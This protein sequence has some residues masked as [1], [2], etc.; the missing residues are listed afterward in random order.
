MT[1]ASEP[2]AK[3]MG[4]EGPPPVADAADDR[5]E[6]VR[7][8]YD[9]LREE[10]LERSRWIW[11]RE[12]TSL[13][14]IVAVYAW[15][16]A[17]ARG[18]AEPG[19]LPLFVAMWSI[20]IVI[21]A[22]AY[23]RSEYDWRLVHKIGD[24]LERIERFAFPVGHEGWNARARRVDGELPEPMPKR[25]PLLALIGRTVNVKRR[26]FWGVVTGLCM[27]ATG[28]AVHER[29]VR[30]PVAGSPTPSAAPPDT[31]FLCAF[32]PASRS[33]ACRR[34]VVDRP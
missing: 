7:A 18:S 27:I 32:D 1:D 9:T 24:Q 22:I 8:E 19:A 17:N 14:G 2:H 34:D 4:H 11:R 31:T 6:L 12:Q 5:V 13:I 3:A 10:T 25:E 23:V 29:I 15:L 16:Y 33:Y 21:A 26:L 20:P 28:A 30:T